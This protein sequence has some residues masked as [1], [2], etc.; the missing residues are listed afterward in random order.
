MADIN[1]ISQDY[2]GSGI[3]L[4]FTLLII[5]LNCLSFVSV[6]EACI[7][8]RNITEWG[9]FLSMLVIK[10]GMKKICAFC[11]EHLS[12][13]NLWYLEFNYLKVFVTLV[14]VYVSM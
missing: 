3:R 5:T 9:V 10:G 7:I 13:Y 4:K 11:R 2:T 8:F 14:S 1:I 6:W 12:P